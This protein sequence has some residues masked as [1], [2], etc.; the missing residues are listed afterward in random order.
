MM[1]SEAPNITGLRCEPAVDAELIIWHLERKSTIV[2]IVAHPR[3]RPG[4]VYFWEVW[5]SRI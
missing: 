2:T 5:E 4:I 3:G 1:G